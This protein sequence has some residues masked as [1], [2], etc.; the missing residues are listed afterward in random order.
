MNTPL[1]PSGR[2]ICCATSVVKS[3]WVNFWCL[4]SPDL[5]SIRLYKNRSTRDAH[6]PGCL[7]S[8]KV[9]YP[10]VFFLNSLETACTIFLNHWLIR[11]KRK[12]FKKEKKYYS[13]L[14]IRPSFFPSKID[15]CIVNFAVLADPKAEGSI[16]TAPPKY[17]FRQFKA[18][19]QSICESNKKLCPP[20]RNF[21]SPPTHE[22]KT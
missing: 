16:H 15:P 19:R 20:P 5:I 14:K 21:L 22:G 8:R 11:K 6:I 2:L 7:A 18:S 3:C 12:F 17:I 4:T 13:I 10:D 9:L 1:V